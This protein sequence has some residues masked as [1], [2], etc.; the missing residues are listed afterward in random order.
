MNCS[1]VH[2]KRRI[3]FWVVV[4]LPWLAGCAGQNLEGI[5]TLN[6]VGKDEKVQREALLKDDSNFKKIKAAISQKKL[7][8]NLTSTEAARLYGNPVA[9]VSQGTASKWVFKG[10]ES[11]LLGGPK[12]YL[13]FDESNRL[14]GWECVRNVCEAESA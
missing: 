5:A 6:A 14:T 12:I 3:F 13:F 9:V 7:T 4:C 8:L 11:G 1:R 10:Q 2:Q